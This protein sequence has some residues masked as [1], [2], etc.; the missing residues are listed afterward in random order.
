MAKKS[1]SWKIG[2]LPY[3]TLRISPKLVETLFLIPNFAFSGRLRDLDSNTSKKFVPIK[4]KKK[5]KNQTFQD[6][7]RFIGLN[8]RV[9]VSSCLYLEE[10]RHTLLVPHYENGIFK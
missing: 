10:R 8:S 7:I 3:H 6:E 4:M 9:L 5:P 1:R 2:L